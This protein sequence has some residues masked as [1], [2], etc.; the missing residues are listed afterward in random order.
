[1]GFLAEDLVSR[2]RAA[3][4][5]VVDRVVVSPGRCSALR[6]FGMYARTAGAFESHKVAHRVL[7]EGL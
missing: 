4:H 5:G 2:Y 1:M 6:P 3:P 7:V